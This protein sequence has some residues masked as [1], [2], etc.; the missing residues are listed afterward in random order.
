MV[1]DGTES[2]IEEYVCENWEKLGIFEYFFPHGVHPSNYLYGGDATGVVEGEIV[3]I[4]FEANPAN[5]F[6]HG[7]D[8]DKTRREYEKY[9]F[10]H[11]I[12]KKYHENK[13]DKLRSMGKEVLTLSELKEMAEE[14]KE[15]NHRTRKRAK[16]MVEEA[17]E[18][19]LKSSPLGQELT[20]IKVK[21]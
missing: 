2:V 19:Y 1:H 5:Y 21:I 18:G 13:A 8:E 15:V 12:T 17:I 14:G 4:E 16:K 3:G 6:R 7:H 9:V 10:C 11:V 20:E